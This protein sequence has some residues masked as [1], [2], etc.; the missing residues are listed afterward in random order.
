MNTFKV[1]VST[2]VLACVAGTVNAGIALPQG[3]DMLVQ[4]GNG[5]PW[6][7]VANPETW[8]VTTSTGPDGHLRYRV[9][10]AAIGD[11]FSV[12]FNTV[13]D[14]DPFISSSFTIQN[15]TGMTQNFTVTTTLPTFPVL[16]APTTMTGSVSGTVGDGDGALAPTGF[17]GTVTTQA[18]G[19]PY[20]EA[21][22]DGLDT[23]SLYTAPQVHNAPLGLTST[24]PTQNFINEVGP[25][26][27][28]SIGIRN[29]FTLTSGDNAAFTST[30]LI[31]PTPSGL[32]VAGL[33][34]LAGLRRRR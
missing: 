10:G 7:A 25:A 29:A 14:P 34:G 26:V 15:M 33:I 24:I 23:R 8:V 28:S 2:A 22:V 4:V 17:G 13:L 21:L 6:S 20:Y 3:W 5:A 11:G 12:S 30:F 18:N 16:F 1:A 31:V 19:R 9:Q 27:I 32:A